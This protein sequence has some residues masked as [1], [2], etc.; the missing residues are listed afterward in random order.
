[1]VNAYAKAYVDVCLEL[2]TDPAR[3]S[4]EFFDARTRQL[5]ADLEKAQTR[6]SDFQRGHGITVSDEKLDVEN[7]RLSELSTQLTAIQ[8]VRAE[9]QSRQNQ[10]LDAAATSPDVMLNPMIQQ[11]QAEVARSEAKVQ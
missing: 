10:A 3:A 5:R 1:M 11:L 8:A 2:R 6:L 7:A 9:S 4:S